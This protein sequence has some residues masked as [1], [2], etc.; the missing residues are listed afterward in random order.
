MYELLTYRAAFGQPS[1]SPFCVKAMCLLNMSGV[2]W[3]RVDTGTPRRMPY[4]KMPVLRDGA[5]LIADSERIRIFLE[6]EAGARF[7]AGLGAT[8]LAW[9]RAL[10]RLAEEH[11]YFLLLHDRWAVDAV[12]EKLRHVY[13]AAIPAPVR[14]PVTG[15]IRRDVVS[16]L[17]AQGIGRLAP[18][19]RMA[20]A[21]ADLSAVETLVADWPFLFGETPTAADASV[22]PMLAAAAASPAETPLSRRVTG[23]TALNGYVE[24]VSAAL[25][26]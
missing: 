7:D 26:P 17:R 18:A 14:R 22:G 6:Q 13:F 19:D 3:R 11:L 25:Y 1:G 20:R 2:A 21:E 4:G 10:I 5:R 16:A 24:R 9:S 15:L 23:S 8:E 12:W